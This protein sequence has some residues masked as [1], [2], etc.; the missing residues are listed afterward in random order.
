MVL[1]AFRENWIRTERILRRLEITEVLV[2]GIDTDVCVLSTAA[3]LFDR[4]FHP[5][6]VSD[7]SASTGGVKC[8]NAALSMLPRYIGA[9]NIVTTADLNSGF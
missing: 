4:G 2:F 6:V 8:H 3:G 1:L 5:I 9:N 7:L